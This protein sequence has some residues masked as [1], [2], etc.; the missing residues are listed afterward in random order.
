MIIV[1]L[2]LNMNKIFVF[3]LFIY[4]ADCAIV[5][6]HPIAD[7]WVNSYFPNAN[8]G[9]SQ[10]AYCYNDAILSATYD[11]V[12]TYNISIVPSSLISANVVWTQDSVDPNEAITGPQT[13]FTLYE[14]SNNWT[15][16]TVTWNNPPTHLSTILSNYQDN[17]IDKI[18]GP[19]TSVVSNYRV[20]GKVLLSLRLTGNYPY[21][22]VYTR[23]FTSPGFR[24]YLQVVT[25]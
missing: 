10:F 5:K 17:D 23:E 25:P 11:I 18:I 4:L 1:I 15:E 21:V 19:V 12:I 24:P 13:V 2:W 20:G 22:S 3:I 9:T 14:V 16:T 6:L 7:S 8:Y